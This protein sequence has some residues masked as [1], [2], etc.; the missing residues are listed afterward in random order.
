LVGVRHLAHDE[1]DPGWLLRQEVLRG[2]E[3]VGQ[4]PRVAVQ[5]RRRA[6]VPV[7]EDKDPGL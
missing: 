3:A 5:V 2:L 1:P 6:E 7:P 4:E